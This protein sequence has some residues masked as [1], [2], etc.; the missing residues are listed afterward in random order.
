M[1]N[2]THYHLF[3]CIS[4]ASTV[5]FMLNGWVGVK[6]HQYCVWSMSSSSETDCREKMRENENSEHC[7]TKK[8][9]SLESGRRT[10]PKE[11]DVSD[12]RA[13]CNMRCKM[14]IF[15]HISWQ[16]S[17]SPFSTLVLCKRKKNTLICS[18]SSDSWPQQNSRCSLIGLWS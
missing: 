7:I 6:I 17:I 2:Y 16:S 5:C 15:A 18:I 9:V 3:T 1:N 13:H 4:I 12:V 11:Q 8:R 10:L 14:I